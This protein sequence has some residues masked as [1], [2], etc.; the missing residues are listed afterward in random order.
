MAAILGE[1]RDTVEDVYEPYLIQSGLLE[2]TPRGRILTNK[3]KQHLHLE[4]RQSGA[5]FS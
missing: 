1:D 5:L 2:R 3:A 4:T